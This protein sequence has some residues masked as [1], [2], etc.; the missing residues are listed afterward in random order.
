RDGTDVVRG[1]EVFEFQYEVRTIADLVPGMGDGE[2]LVGTAGDDQLA[3][4]M[5]YDLVQGLD[6]NDFLGGGAANDTLEGGAGD[7]YLRGDFG[8]DLLAGGDGIDVAGYQGWSGDYVV[9]LD[10]ATG[11]LTIA[12]R[13]FGRDGT[14]RVI[15]VEQFAFLDGVWSAQDL[16]DLQLA[17]VAPPPTEPAFL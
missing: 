3:G 16:V 14:D 9:T 4:A 15:G 5:G 2:V 17:G 11:E 6:G 7:D 12:D 1:A 8:D 10:S 13:M